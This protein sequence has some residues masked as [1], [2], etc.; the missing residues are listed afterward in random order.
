[1]KRA[2]R[3]HTFVLSVSFDKSCNRRLALREVRD[4]IY[5]HH[6]CTQYD[7]AEPGEFRI[8]SIKPHKETK[9]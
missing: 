9:Q 7:E 2:K 3:V 6:Y 8:R 4:T 5:G 1:M